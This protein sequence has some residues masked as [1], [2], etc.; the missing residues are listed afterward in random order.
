MCHTISL[1]ILLFTYHLD[2]CSLLNSPNPRSDW[3]DSKNLLCDTYMWVFFLIWVK[4]TSGFNDSYLAPKSRLLCGSLCGYGIPWWPYL[5]CI[6]FFS[7]FDYYGFWILILSLV[8]KNWKVWCGKSSCPFAAC[9]F[10]N[11]EFQ[12]VPPVKWCGFA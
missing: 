3:H 12:W 6:Y 5:I 4:H 8:S 11:G 7:S 2:V 10:S 9:L 1:Y